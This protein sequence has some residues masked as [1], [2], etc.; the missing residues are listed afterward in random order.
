MA[1]KK[2]IKRMTMEELIARKNQADESRKKIIDIEVPAM[3]GAIAAHKKPLQEY[4]AFMDS[5]DDGDTL[6]N[7]ID[8]FVQIIYAHCP[9]LQNKELQEAYECQEPSDIVLKVFGDSIGAIKSAA[10]KIMELYGIDDEVAV[11]KN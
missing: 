5:L 4:T 8:Q 10:M 11:V 9:M 7:S 6:E 1:A 2:Q 3:G